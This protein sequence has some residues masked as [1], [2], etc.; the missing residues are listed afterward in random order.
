MGHWPNARPTRDGLK[1]KDPTHEIFLAQDRELQQLR[2]RFLAAE[3]NGALVQ[4]LE[5]LVRTAIFKPANALVAFLLQA[6]ADRMDGA[7]P[8]KPGE[9]FKG[10]ESIQAGGLFGFFPLCRASYDHPGKKQGPYPA[11]DA[12][13]LEGGPTPAWARWRCLEGAEEASLQKAEDPWRETGGIHLSARRIQRLVQPVGAAAQQW[14]AREAWRPEP[15][16]QAV[17]IMEVS[18]DAS[19]VP[20]RPA[21][22]EGRAGKHSDGSA[23]TRR[24]NLGCVF[25]Q[26]QRDEMGHP[27][28]DYDST[29]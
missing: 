18:G 3:P 5:G 29:T 16:R 8:P 22:L 24:A 4:P 14:Q 28:R 2:A 26:H 10:R 27:V 13:G 15:A 23:K 19:G 21:E 1:K 12:L 25:T 6:A 17:P 11:D 7:D 20:R 9:H